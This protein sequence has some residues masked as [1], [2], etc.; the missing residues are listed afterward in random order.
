MTLSVEVLRKLHRIHRQLA[1][2]KSRLNR[3]PKQVAATQQAIQRG[4][5]EVAQ[6]KEVLKQVRKQSADQQLQLRERETKIAD[7]QRKLN[8]CKAETLDHPAGVRSGALPREAVETGSLKDFVHARPGEFPQAGIELQDFTQ[9][10]VE[11]ILQERVVAG[12]T[13]VPVHQ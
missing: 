5:Q 9:E 6:T 2:L 1:D 3:G 13:I 11:L 4:E 8:E 10:G 7:L 12:C